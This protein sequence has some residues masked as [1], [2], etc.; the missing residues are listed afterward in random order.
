M[1]VALCSPPHSVPAV[2]PSAPRCPPPGESVEVGTD[3]GR[4]R[5]RKG[6]RATKSPQ[7][8]LLAE[9]PPQPLRRI[10]WP[11]TT[12]GGRFSVAVRCTMSLPIVALYETCGHRPAGTGKGSR[13]REAVKHFQS[14]ASNLRW[15]HQPGMI[16][17]LAAAGT[18]WT[19]ALDLAIPLVLAVA[20]PSGFASD[21]CLFDTH[22]RA[23]DNAR[24]I[25]PAR[26]CSTCF[27]QPACAS[28]YSSCS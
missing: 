7:G 25:C 15:A 18:R 12:G 11:S 5:G 19:L 22:C 9:E 6:E 16:C 14:P 10:T 17:L 20:Q 24:P 26:T 23:Y 8:T 2:P 21:A 3:G 1:P 28:W 27:S 13:H 4:E